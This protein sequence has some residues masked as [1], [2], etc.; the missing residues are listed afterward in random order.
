MGPLNLTITVYYESRCVFENKIKL[1]HK[2]HCDVQ[3][4]TLYLSGLSR[5]L[6]ITHNMD[7]PPSQYWYCALIILFAFSSHMCSTMFIISMTFDR[8]YSITAP[9]KA[10]SFNTV[11]RAKITILFIVFICFFWTLPQLFLGDNS[12]KNCVPYTKA[13][14][15]LGQIYY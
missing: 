15:L 3:K 1:P 14:S 10:A 5:Y 13:T 2:S 6:N 4:I 7:M 8:L 9:L 11:R 12:D